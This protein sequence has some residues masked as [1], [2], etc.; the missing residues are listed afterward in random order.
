M[1]WV[2]D[3]KTIRNAVHEAASIYPIKRV[4]LFGSYA[5]GTATE[6]SDLDFLV[7]FSDPSAT[8]LNLLGFQELLIESLNM[9]VD[10]VRWPLHKDCE[11]EIDAKVCVYES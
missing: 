10:V 9:D 7:E 2:L 11:L 6:K 4:E 8:L 3:M 5:N 1:I